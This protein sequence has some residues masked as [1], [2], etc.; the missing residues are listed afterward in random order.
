VVAS[1]RGTEQLSCRQG[2][3]LLS[4]GMDNIGGCTKLKNILSKA[5]RQIKKEKRKV[6]YR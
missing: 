5:N 4:C 2:F 6:K 1:L 3:S